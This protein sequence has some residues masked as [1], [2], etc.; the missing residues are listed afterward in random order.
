M[1]KFL[2]SNTQCLLS[3]KPAASSG[4]WSGNASRNRSGNASRNRCDVGAPSSVHAEYS[5]RGRGGAPPFC[6]FIL[7][8]MSVEVHEC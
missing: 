8:F 3:H 5:S 7:R 1:S 4:N 2:R 6:E